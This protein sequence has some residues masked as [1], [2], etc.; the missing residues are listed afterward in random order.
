MNTAANTGSILLDLVDVHGTSLPRGNAEFLL[1]NQRLRTLDRAFRTKL[2]GAPLMLVDVPGFPDG[3][4]ELGINPERYRYKKRFVNVPASDVLHVRETFFLDPATAKPKFPSLAQLK[5]QLKKHPNLT[6]I[7][8]TWPTLGDLEKAGLLNLHAKSQSLA[9]P[10]GTRIFDHIE[11]LT[12]ARPARLFARVSSTL[13]AA[14]AQ[15]PLFAEASGISHSF[16]K[17]WQ[18]LES[19]SSFKTKERQA[20]LQITFAKDTKGDGL[21]MID[22]DIDDNQGLAHAFDVI[23]HKLTG[24]DTHPYD[25]HQMLVALQNIHPGY[26][27]T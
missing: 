9:L 25:I 23:G 8:S 26:E 20:N 11:S 3:L 4:A 18:R 19:A 5:N 2:K 12:E 24:R 22:L 1:Y 14:I 27:L 6:N 16:P 15:S 13:H 10:D 21:W 17:G 7:L